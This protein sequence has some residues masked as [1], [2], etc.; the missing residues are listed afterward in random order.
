MMMSSNAGAIM[1]VGEGTVND[2]NLC[3]PARRLAGRDGKHVSCFSHAEVRA[4]V[5]AYNE[6]AVGAFDPIPF[7]LSGDQQRDSLHLYQ[8]LLSRL[9]CIDDSCIANQLWFM[10]SP[11]EMKGG[12]AR[13]RDLLQKAVKPKGPRSGNDWLNTT[14][15]EKVMRQYEDLYHGFHFL[16]VSPS[17]FYDVYPQS[18]PHEEIMAYPRGAFI[19]N[20]DK[21]GQRGSHWVAVFYERLDANGKGGV[22][23]YFDSTGRPPNRPLERFLNTY[24]GEE[25]KIRINR[26]EHQKKNNE[27]GLYAVFYILSRLKG[28]NLMNIKERITD[29]DMNEFRKVL[30]NA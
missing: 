16:G 11:I 27:C 19:F 29:E 2:S 13:L 25:W 24:F 23:E 9:Q 6:S 1:K 8:H 12:V 7:N 26:R 5:Q 15:L 10:S 3:S 18:F 14:D 30:F 17:D 20:L 28:L 4:M 21:L 22:V